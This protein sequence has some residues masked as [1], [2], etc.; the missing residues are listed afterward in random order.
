MTAEGCWDAD[1]YI[2]SCNIDG[3]NIWRVQAQTCAAVAAE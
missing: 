1:A 2:T 3:E